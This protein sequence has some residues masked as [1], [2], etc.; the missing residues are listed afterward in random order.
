MALNEGPAIDRF[1][2]AP[3]TPFY[4]MWW[5]DPGVSDLVHTPAATVTGATNPLSTYYQ[6]GGRTSGHGLP[7]VS[8]PVNNGLTASKNSLR[9]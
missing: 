1:K 2:L 4:L 3:K 5:P 9:T 6:M 8:V 7:H